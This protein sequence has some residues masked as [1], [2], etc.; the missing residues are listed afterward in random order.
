MTKT[1]LGSEAINFSNMSDDQKARIFA[2]I[3]KSLEITEDESEIKTS[4]LF[5]ILDVSW[6]QLT[7]MSIR[8]KRT[9]TP[10]TGIIQVNRLHALGNAIIMNPGDELEFSLSLTEK[11][12]V[13]KSE[14]IAIFHGVK[15]P[16]TFT[17][18]DPKLI[19]AFALEI[20]KAYG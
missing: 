7:Q 18:N 20:Y 16:V 2:A 9:S 12:I 10:A 19:T 6:I 8:M 4:G 1:P 3:A 14:F 13:D 15:A 5:S 17:P 11:L